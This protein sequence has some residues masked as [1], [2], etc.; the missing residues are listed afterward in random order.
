MAKLSLLKNKWYFFTNRLE[1]KVVH[2]FLKVICPKVNI[3]VRLE[4]ELV[5]NDILVQQVSY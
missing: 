4:F 1:D 5:Y 2:T 3:A